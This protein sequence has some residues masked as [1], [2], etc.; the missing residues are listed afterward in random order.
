MPYWGY[1]SRWSSPWYDWDDDDFYYRRHTHWVSSPPVVVTHPIIT[2]AAPPQQQQQPQQQPQ[3]QSQQPQPI[4]LHINNYGAQIEN[5]QDLPPAVAQFVQRRQPETNNNSNNNPRI[6]PNRLIEPAPRQPIPTHPPPTFPLPPGDPFR[7]HTLFLQYRNA[8]RRSRNLP[9]RQPYTDAEYAEDAREV[10]ELV[11]KG[12]Y[13][14][15]LRDLEETVGRE[16]GVRQMGRMLR[17]ADERM[18]R[19][20]GGGTRVIR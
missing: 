2:Q 6:P 3:Q 20:G 4:N 13:S 16:S 12:P 14:G 17:G 1:R 19:G 18:G 15:T 11:M 9:L 8:S 5:E 7:D 10:Y